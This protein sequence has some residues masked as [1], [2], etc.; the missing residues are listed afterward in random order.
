MDGDTRWLLRLTVGCLAAMTLSLALLDGPLA[1]W[2]KAHDT[3]PAIWDQLLATLEYAIGI[4]PWRWLGTT[5]LVAGTLISRAVPR[6]EGA[7][8]K[9]LLVT[10]SHFVASNLMIWDKHFSGRLR[11][12]EWHTGAQWLQHGGSFPSGH[13]TLVGSLAL[14]IAVIYPRTRNA[15]LGMLAFVGCARIAV[16]AHWASDVFAGLALTAFVT[17]ACADAVRRAPWP[18]PPSPPPPASP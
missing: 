9:W 2:V 16:S 8:K 3:H 4:E 18:S 13:M 11:P 14:P 6:W 1:A 10:L 5:I 17:W 15:M 12:H 7:A